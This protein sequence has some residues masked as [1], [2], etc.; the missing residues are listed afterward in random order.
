MDS[1]KNGSRHGFRP[2]EPVEAGSCTESVRGSDVVPTLRN[3]GADHAPPALRWRHDDL[4]R[5]SLLGRVPAGW[6]EHLLSQPAVEGRLSA[7]AASSFAL[8]G[9]LKKNATTAELCSCFPES[10][11]P[12]LTHPCSLPM[13]P[14]KES[15]AGVRRHLLRSILIRREVRKASCK[16]SAWTRRSTPIDRGIYLGLEL[17]SRG[18]LASSGAGE[19]SRRPIR[20]SILGSNDSR[21]ET[22]AGRAEVHIRI[23][24]I[25]M[26]QDVCKRA[27]HFELDSFCNGEGFAHSGEGGVEGIS[28][29]G[30]HFHRQTQGHECGGGCQQCAAPHRAAEGRSD[31]LGRHRR[32]H[33]SIWRNRRR[34][35]ERAA[36]AHADRGNLGKN[37]Y[38]K[39]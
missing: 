18:N 27:F 12:D 1:R 3:D 11:N 34:E 6:R 30:D 29:G 10:E 16:E 38:K 7:R 5:R 8:I 36:A 17:D 14:R 23:A 13:M 24:Q 4:R 39:K 37:E 35:I 21:D 33:A 15:F 9:E 28:A 22:E 2:G 25:G 20:R 31:P 26:V 19:I 32:H